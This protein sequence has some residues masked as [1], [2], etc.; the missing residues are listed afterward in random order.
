MK[1]IKSPHPLWAL[2]HKKQGTELR[3][4]RGRYYLYEYKTVYDKVKK[5]PR[6]ISGRLLGSI[7]EKDG[8]LPSEKRELE[9]GLSEKILKGIQCKEFGV[10][11]L[12]VTRFK[13]YTL[14]LKKTFPEEYKDILAI[15]YCRFIYRCPLKS[16]P[17]RLA[18]SF[19]PEQ[20]DM[21]PFGEKHSSG[22]LN[23][24]G[25]QRDKIL[26]YM[27]SFIKQEEYILMDA[28]DIFSNSKNISLTKSGYSK[29]L[30]VDTQ[31]NLMYIYSADSRMPL[32]Y[33]L[34]PGNIRDVKAF[35][36]SL[37]EVGLKKAVIVADK[38]FYSES[39]VKLM[40]QE[41]LQFIIPLKRDNTMIDYQSLIHNNFKSGTS[42]FEH[43]KRAIWYNIFSLDNELTLTMYL[44][45]QLRVKEDADYLKRIKTVPEKYS[46]EKYHEKKHRFG[47]IA[48][49][50]QINESAQDTYEAYKSR[51]D[52]EVLFDSMKNVMEADHTC[53][54][55]EQ[56]LQGWMF[57]NHIVLQWYQYLYIELKEKNLLKSISV[58]DVIQL[59]TDVK[60]IRINNQ[61]YLNEFIAFTQKM[62]V[63]LGIDLHNT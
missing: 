32:Y 3:Y 53:M 20:L 23:R 45:E 1:N 58:N 34:L 19:L 40:L 38:G 15:A 43:E 60:K 57:V 12:I 24:I 18:S 37:L 44:D 27:K 16:I 41:Q 4:I 63:K 36:N 10:T 39:N 2:S 17:F 25:S 29:N 14:I 59:M 22:I 6:K 46:I 52:I 49:L 47:T 42:F 9:Q 7:T 31:F 62:M 26:Q 28:P 5:R 13:E 61:W 11:Q 51:M 8:F 30:Q 54:Q 35:K 50:S 55:N 56:T 21:K 33:R 48:L